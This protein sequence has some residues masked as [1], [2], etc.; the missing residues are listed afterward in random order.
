MTATKQRNILNKASAWPLG[1]TLKGKQ[2]IYL[3]PQ[4]A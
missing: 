2:T 3:A 1:D 4:P